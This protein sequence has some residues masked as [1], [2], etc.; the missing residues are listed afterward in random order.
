MAFTHNPGLAAL[1]NYIV[2]EETPSPPIAESVAKEAQ[3]QAAIEEI[4]KEIQED[5]RI[6]RPKRKGFS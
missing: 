6:R 4:A 2:G 5:A 3:Q 1:H